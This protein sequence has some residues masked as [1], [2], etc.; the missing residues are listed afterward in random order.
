MIKLKRVYERIDVTDGFRIL[1]DRLWPR[2]IR[3]STPN[4]DKWLKGV[5]PSDELRRWFAHDPKKW[6]TFKSR[7][8]AELKDNHD[9]DKLVEIATENDTITLLFAAKDEKHNNAVVLL[10]VLKRRLAHAEKAARKAAR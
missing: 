9:L 3:S 10:D 5:A 7:Y 6:A 4:I 2:G 8:K 1:V